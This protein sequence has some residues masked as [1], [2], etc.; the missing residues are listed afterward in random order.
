MTGIEW[1][2]ALAICWWVIRG[3]LSDLV[4]AMRG[5]APPR[6]SE[7]R[8]R[9]AA[10][11]RRYGARNY[12]ADLYSD[13]WKTARAKREARL[14]QRLEH[15]REHG[16]GPTWRQRAGERWSAA[17][18]RWEQRMAERQA[19]REQATARPDPEPVAPA[20]PTGPDPGVP[21]QRVDQDPEQTNPEQEQRREPVEPVTVTPW[22]PDRDRPEPQ[23][24]TAR[25][26]PG[27]RWEV[28][29]TPDR[30]AGEP[31]RGDGDMAE[32]TGL[33]TAIAF[34][35]GHRQANEH[36][37]SSWEGFAASLQSGDVGGEV[38]AEC[39]RAAELQAELA[40]CCGRIEQRLQAQLNVRDAYEATP[41]AGSKEFVTSE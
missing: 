14:E 3:G 19:R 4:L 9:A 18:G 6:V 1:L 8:A 27:G 33:G 35:A 40:A 10:T 34:V 15:I 39:S 16:P 32:V 2:I 37:V 28:V 12:M 30:Q 17:W 5:S 36:A 31:T 21:R 29:D 23:E 41:D 20:A 24:L 38:L 13:A 11:G 25:P 26:G 22:H 7:G